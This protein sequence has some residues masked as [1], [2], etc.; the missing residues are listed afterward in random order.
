VISKAPKLKSSEEVLD[1][2]PDI[3]ND[4]FLAQSLKQVIFMIKLIMKEYKFNLFQG[5]IVHSRSPTN[6]YV[7]FHW[8]FGGFKK[9]FVDRW[10]INHFY[11]KW[12][13]LTWAPALIYYVAGCYSMR[14]YDNAAYDFFYF[15]D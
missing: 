9:Y 15:S 11:K 1:I 6:Q 14:Q 5:C 8:M 12:I 13:R 10:F 2:T 4:L 7:N 3:N